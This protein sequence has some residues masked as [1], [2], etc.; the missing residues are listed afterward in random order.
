MSINEKLKKNGQLCFFNFL[1]QMEL[2]RKELVK[3]AGMAITVIIM[4]MRQD[5]GTFPPSVKNE[6][7]LWVVSI[8]NL[9]PVVQI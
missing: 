9:G 4:A 5:F 8:C 7:F 6:L 2:L 1:F 3:T